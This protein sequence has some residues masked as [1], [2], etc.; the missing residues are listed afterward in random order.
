MKRAGSA[1][2]IVEKSRTSQQERLQNSLVCAKFHA[3]A[4]S[5]EAD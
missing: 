3:L 5:G 4:L 2:L 1:Q